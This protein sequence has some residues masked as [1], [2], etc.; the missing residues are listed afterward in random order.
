MKQIFFMSL[1][2]FF[3]FQSAFAKTGVANMIGTSPESK[4]TGSIK[5][6]ETKQG[7]KIEALIQNVPTG[8]KGF[9]IHEF[10]D[11]GDLGKKAG[12]HYNP[13]N[14]AHGN[15]IKN[16]VHKAHAGDLG[17]ITINSDGT[18]TLTT[19]IKNLSLSGGKF[20]VGGRAVILHEK[21]D[22]FSQPTG[23]AGARIGCAPIII[24]GN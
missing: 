17:N 10:G 18:G 23:N 11:C 15:A 16:G 9:H 4:V 7:L 19:T 6:E 3:L 12:G 24:T 8:D 13:Q 22:D 20:S 1:F 2:S 14:H 21:T 5:F